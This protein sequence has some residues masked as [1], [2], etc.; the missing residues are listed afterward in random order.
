ML[1][2]NGKVAL[3]T[4]GG[5]GIGREISLELANHGANVIVFNRDPVELENV[6]KEI[7]EKNVRALGLAVDVTRFK[8][9]EKAVG[10]VINS[11]GRIDILV[12]NVGAFPRKLF[13]EMNEEDWFNIININLTSTF[14]VTR[15]VAPYM[16]KQ[17]YG[18]II[19]ISS[20]TGL[21]HG[22]PGLVHYGAAKAG[23][24]GFTK[25]LAAELAPYNITVNAIAPGPI[26]TPGVKSIWTPED[27]KIQEFIN[28]LKRFG[29]PSDV[30]KLTVFL[31][32][33]YSEFITGQV[34]VVDGGLTLVNPRIV[35]GEAL[36]SFKE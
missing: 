26:L 35:V 19:N 4:G 17:R 31:A 8:D 28:P 15:A 24:V 33:D 2:L 29:M 11:M 9:V 16:V 6:L 30:A 3:V 22:V 18:R 12:N 21:Y 32:S 25:C 34:I 13:L 20:I 36:K 10:E 14:Y 1:S 5:K 27:I 23:V 7:R